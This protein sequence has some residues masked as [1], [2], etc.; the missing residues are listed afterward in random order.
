M[1]HFFSGAQVTFGN[2]VKVALEAGRWNLKNANKGIAAAATDTAANYQGIELSYQ[3]GKLVRSGIAYRH[4]NSEVFKTAR[5]YNV[6]GDPKDS[7]NIWSIGAKYAFDKNTALSAAY[8]K[9]TKADELNR[10]VSVQF[11]YKGT[12]NADQGSWGAY[13]AYR[14]VAPNA[15]LAPTFSTDHLTGG[16]TTYGTK[17]WDFGIG[18]VPLKNVLTQIGYF[19]GKELETKDKAETLF[20]RVSFFF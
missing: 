1:D 4:F 13:A 3:S 5:L 18:Y 9:N 8:A 12:K 2:K 6:S 14:Y 7:A 19:N 10:A 16:V 20:G 15:G 11:D 17:G